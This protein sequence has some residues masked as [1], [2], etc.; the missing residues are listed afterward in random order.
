MSH[1]SMQDSKAEHQMQSERDERK[2][3]EQNAEGVL[4]LDQ[5]YF[6]STSQEE[7]VVRSSI[8]RYEM[9]ELRTHPGAGC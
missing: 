4:N 2:P 7:D 9:N 5:R 1:Q 8:V 6:S 3:K